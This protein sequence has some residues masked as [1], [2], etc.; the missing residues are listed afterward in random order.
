MEP[1]LELQPSPYTPGSVAQVV[2]GRDALLTSARRDLAF[3]KSFPKLKGQLEI[4]VG[5]RGVGK[6]SLLRTIEADAL[7]LGFSTCWVTGGDGQLIDDLMRA[8][9]NLSANWKTKTKDALESIFSRLSVSVAG[10]SLEPGERRA[11][12]R[13]G[14]GRLLQEALQQA[15][16]HA[17]GAGLVL[18]IDEVQASDPDS[19]RSLAY[20]WQHLQSEASELPLLCYCAGL[21]HTQDV[22]TDAVSFGERFRYRQLGNLDPESARLALL[23]PASALGVAWADDAAEFALNIADG[24]PFF[25]QVVGDETWQAAGYPAVGATIKQDDVGVAMAG[26]REVQLAFFRSRWAKA[27]PLEQ[28][29]LSAMAQAAV[30]SGQARRADIAELMGRT[31]QSLSVVRRA[32]MDKGLIDS[33]AHGY[34]EFTAPGFAEYVRKEGGRRSSGI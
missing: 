8:L 7:G 32:L 4:Y 21:S 10:V 34:T 25:L 15:G 18:L 20:A 27:S 30:G 6:T 16:T 5:A 31:S 9:I 11:L 23:E 26:F 19:L 14:S 22:I 13:S 24:Y 12:D 28:E 33:P 3:A 2:Y 1:E 17:P 29:F